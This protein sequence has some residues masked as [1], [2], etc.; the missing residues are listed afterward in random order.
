MGN[1]M[2]K[3][4]PRP[5]IGRQQFRSWHEAL[6]HAKHLMQAGKIGAEEYKSIEMN[7]HASSE[8]ATAYVKAR[9]RGRNDA[10]VIDGGP[11]GGAVD[12]RPRFKE[13]TQRS[14]NSR[15]HKA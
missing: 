1:Q 12:W 13:N 14:N 15:D 3:I 11:T 7:A 4:K 8:D 10:N 2:S 5:S 9:R 6:G